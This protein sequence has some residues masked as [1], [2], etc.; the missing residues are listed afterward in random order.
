MFFWDGS[1]TVEADLVEIEMVS[2]MNLQRFCYV[3]QSSRD[4]GI[5]PSFVCEMCSI[6]MF[7]L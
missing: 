4:K 1:A 2:R 6:L 3:Q 7:A 5:Q